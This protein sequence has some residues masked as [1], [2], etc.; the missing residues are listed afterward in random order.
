MCNV[1]QGNRACSKAIDQ[2]EARASQLRWG[3]QPP[4]KI[5]FTKKISC[6][7]QNLER[8]PL[9]QNVCITSWFSNYFNLKLNI[10]NMKNMIEFERLK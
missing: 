9:L 10:K 4:L 6:C 3:I 7:I 5:C 8:T 1:C 2:N